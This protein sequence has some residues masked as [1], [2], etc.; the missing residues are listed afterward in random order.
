MGLTGS[1]VSKEAAKVK[2]DELVISKVYESKSKIYLKVIIMDDN[3]ATIV[4][5]ISQG[6]LLF[7]NL[8]KVIGYLLP[9]GSFSEILP[10]LAY[11]FLGLP[12]P[13]TV[14]AMLVICL[15]TDVFG[16]LGL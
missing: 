8:K 12:M 6:R 1:E 2:L 5:G 10:V 11:V 14:L 4:S 13:L 9:A 7:N 15:V 3:F 16:A